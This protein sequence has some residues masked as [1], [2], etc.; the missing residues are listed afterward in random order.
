MS[1]QKILERIKEFPFVQKSFEIDQ[2]NFS[3]FGC[4]VGDG[5]SDII[6]ELCKKIDESGEDVI[7]SQVKEKF[8]LIRFYTL[9]HSDQVDEWITEAENKSSKTCEVCGKPGKQQNRGW[10]YT[11]CNKCWNKKL[12]E[13][14]L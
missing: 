6:Y 9:G 13:E 11:M 2:T 8:G 10:L 5:W 4:E 14:K 3:M 12:K 1:N 7:I